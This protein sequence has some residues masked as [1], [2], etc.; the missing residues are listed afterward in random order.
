MELIY[1]LIA[2]LPII[3]IVIGIG[4]LIAGFTLRKSK[5]KM[6]QGFFIAG[7]LCIGI[8]LLIGIA[9]FLLGAFGVGPVP[10]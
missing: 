2:Y 8:C 10:N 5:E 9:L 7:S 3:R 1:L 4:L 6:S